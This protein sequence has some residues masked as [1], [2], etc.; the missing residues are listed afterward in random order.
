MGFQLTIIC[1]SAKKHNGQYDTT[2]SI[3]ELLKS[4]VNLH[5]WS[6]FHQNYFEVLQIMGVTGLP[7]TVRSHRCVWLAN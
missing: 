6:T 4:V 1:I 5:Q 3:P 2:V 7:V